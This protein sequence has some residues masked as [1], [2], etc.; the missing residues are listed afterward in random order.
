VT[1]YLCQF[2]GE[3]DERPQRAPQEAG[4]IIEQ[5]R[6]VIDRAEAE[7]RAMTSEEDDAWKRMDA[8]QER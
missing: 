1:V 3:D 5:M 4:G 2:S 7:A 8:D 6:A